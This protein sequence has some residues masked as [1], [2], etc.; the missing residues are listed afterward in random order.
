[1]PL[2]GGAGGT[3]FISDPRQFSRSSVSP[4]EQVG[5]QI[6]GVGGCRPSFGRG[7]RC[8]GCTDC[9]T[10]G[11]ELCAQPAL[12]I[13][14]GSSISTSSGNLFLAILN[15]SI[16]AGAPGLFGIAGRSLGQAAGLRLRG[17]ELGKILSRCGGFSAS[18]GGAC[19]LDACRQQCSGETQAE[20]PEH[21]G[22]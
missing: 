5:K 4:A 1:M 17:A 16:D 7:G 18:T 21:G 3:P 8:A 20:G 11:C 2:T 9:G 6:E 22:S 15:H 19:A 10:E 12:S 14:S 13:C